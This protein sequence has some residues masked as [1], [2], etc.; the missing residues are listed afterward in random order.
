MNDEQ[1]RR[2]SELLQARNA[3]DERISAIIQ[4]PMTAGHAGEWIAAEIFGIMLERSASA[5]AIDGHFTSGPL[6][7]RTVNVK[8]YLKQESVL[9]V[10]EGAAPDYY[11]V[12]AGP[13]PSALTSQ[14]ATRPWCV[15]SVYLFDAKRLI[16]ELRGRRVK[17][18]IAASVLK[19]QWTAAEIYPR[20]NNALVTVRP[21]QAQLL[22]LFAP[23]VIAAPSA[24]GS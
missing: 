18:G 5:R 12:L 10:S 17:I 4:R 21:D 9:D 24:D 16:D 6:S 14:G 2:L 15:E 8:W 23:D 11:L 19:A 22:R 3:I 20:A 7:G 1:L 13:R